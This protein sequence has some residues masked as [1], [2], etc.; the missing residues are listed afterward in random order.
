MAVGAALLK[1]SLSPALRQ[2]EKSWLAAPREEIE[3]AKAQFASEA[4][5]AANLVT[6][7]I[8]AAYRRDGV[9]VVRGAVS[10]AWRELLKDGCET[11]QDEAGPFAQYLHKPTDTGT[12]FTDLELARRLPDFAAFALHGPCAAVAAE[13]MES[14]NMRYLYDQLF[15]KEKGV[16][17]PTPWHQDQGYWRVSGE[18]VGSVF[19]A[20]DPVKASDGLS[21]IPGSQA[22][23]LHNPKHFADGTPYKGTKLPQMPDI[24]AMIADKQI[25]ELQFDLMPGDVL[26]FS[27]HTVHGGAGNWGRALSTR[28][29]GD[30]AAFWARP[31]EGAVPSGDV[32]LADGQSLGGRPAAF[33]QVWSRKA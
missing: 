25:S 31:G 7:D 18:Q 29:A 9:V 2:H 6:D 22:W 5:A 13:V 28:W 4:A 16:S 12:F 33:P 19:V 30:D 24:S 26:V 8:K 27:G 21:F 10:S 3:R 17:V 14:T 32:R 23:Q 11:A 1:T 15:V 20:L